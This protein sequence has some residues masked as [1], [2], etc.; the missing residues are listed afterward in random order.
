MPT[1]SN[2]PHSLVGKP[3]SSA[4]NPM[5]ALA[6]NPMAFMAHL[7]ASTATNRAVVTKG[8]ASA[9]KPEHIFAYS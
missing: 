6:G 5:R 1:I 3:D 2:I 4:A 8:T 7:I 9:N